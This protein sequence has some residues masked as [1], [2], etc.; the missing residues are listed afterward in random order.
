MTQAKADNPSAKGKPRRR[1][2]LLFRLI[3]VFF[4]LFVAFVLGEIAVRL[5]VG[6]P[7][8]EHEPLMVVRANPYRGY[9][10]MPSTPHYTYHYPVQINAL[11]LRGP[12][13]EAKKPGEVRVFALGDSMTYGQGVAD[14]QTIPAV[15]QSND[16]GRTFTVVNGGVRGY[17][18]NQELGMLRELGP[19][20]D[21]DVI[22]L[23]WYWN[24]LND[25]PIADVNATFER[26]GPVV[27][28]TKAKIEGWLW[29]KWQVRALLRRSAL[30]MWLHDVYRG[31]SQ[32]KVDTA[33]MDAGVKRFQSHLGEFR[34]LAAQQNASLL[35]A[36]VPDPTS[37][38]GEHM[39]DVYRA[40]IAAICTEQR[41]PVI[42]L[43]HS[44]KEA[45]AGG[46]RLPVVPFDGHFNA[47]ANAA[48]GKA[49]AKFLL[50]HLQG[51]HTS[52]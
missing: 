18:T 41:V 45:D 24:D 38:R 22:I 47:D 37:L 25:A 31:L 13:V 27:F 34:A 4:G 36:I 15:A 20:I 1:R 10:M 17:A 50:E 46:Y 44:A 21:P 3:A 8:A 9:E 42:D 35:V 5:F 12:E 23:F 32:P 29:V 6:S 39:S 33:G 19:T 16:S 11:G 26:S 48:M 51:A 30:I 43:L 28:E 52:P 7:L 14:D 40:K 49:T 2:R